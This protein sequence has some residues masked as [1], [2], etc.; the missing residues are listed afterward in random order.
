MKGRPSRH[1]RRSPGNH[2]LLIENQ[3]DDESIKRPSSTR[4]ARVRER[5]STTPNF[6]ACQ[7]CHFFAGLSELTDPPQLITP[8]LSA[9]LTFQL[10]NWIPLNFHLNRPRIQTFSISVKTSAPNR[11]HQLENRL[12]D[13]I[14]CNETDNISSAFQRFLFLFGLCFQRTYFAFYETQ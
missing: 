1:W 3:P 2:L 6:T 11:F 12:P 9:S 8:A 14:S 7:R 5:R 13:E 4:S 10:I